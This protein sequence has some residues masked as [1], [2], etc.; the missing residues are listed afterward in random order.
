MTEDYYFWS[1]RLLI[2]KAAQAEGFDVYVATHVEKYREELKQ[3]GLLVVSTLFS[4]SNKNLL[5]QIK[6]LIQL[7]RVF[8]KIKPDI[9][10]NV[11]LKAILF[12]T[13]SSWMTRVPQT[14]NLVAGLGVIFT[15]QSKKYRL[16]SKLARMVARILFSSSN[17]WVIAQNQDDMREIHCMAPKARMKLVRGSGVDTTKYFPVSEPLGPVRVT[18]LA[19]MLWHKGIGEFVKASRILKSWGENLDMQ[20]VGGLDFGNPACISE[21]QLLD[22][23]SVGLINWLGHQTDIAR[24]WAE[25]HI[26]V[27][28][29]YREGLPK[30][31]L[32][33]AACGKPMIAADTPGCREIVIDQHNGFLVPVQDAEALARAIQKLAHDSDL[34]VKMGNYSRQLVCREFSNEHVIEQTMELYRELVPTMG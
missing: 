26:A 7:I 4:R 32:E 13:I 21:Q 28:P 17:I 33:A 25:S 15:D 24:I 9:V 22:W 10:H 23:Q 16:I 14:I 29:S 1:H 34:R 20:L 31:L 8:K 19:R 6:A 27:L 2:A 12:G 5:I 30:S 18:L 3:Q 11:A